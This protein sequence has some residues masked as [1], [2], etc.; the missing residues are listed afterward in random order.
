M[1]NF[2]SSDKLF[3]FTKLRKD[4]K[5]WLEHY[6]II[7]P[8]SIPAYV[9]SFVYHIPD[10]MIRHENLNFYNQQGME[11]LNDFIRLYYFRS[12]NKK[13]NDNKYLSQ[14]L[15]KRNRIEY[16]NLNFFKPE[17][18]KYKLNIE[19]VQENDNMDNE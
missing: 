13:R 14:L 8:G 11:K 17:T 6:L 9:H 7:S 12:S 10:M 19:E 2:S 1:Q 4:L 16:F 5:N 18:P 3:N 15:E